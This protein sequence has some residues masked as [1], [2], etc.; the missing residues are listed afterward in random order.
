[1]VVVAVAGRGRRLGAASQRL[2]PPPPTLLVPL[3]PLLGSFQE[4]MFFLPPSKSSP[5]SLLRPVL[6]TKHGSNSLGQRMSLLKA[7]QEFN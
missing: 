6:L 1:M 7:R 4:A 2:G 5:E 3:R